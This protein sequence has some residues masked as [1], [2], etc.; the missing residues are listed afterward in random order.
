MM[1]KLFGPLLVSLSFV[2]MALPTLAHQASDKGHQDMHK[3]QKEW[4]I[5]GDAKAVTRTIEI[6][7]LDTMRFVPEQITVKQGE[8]IR[9]TVKNVGKVM[10]ELVIGTKQELDMHAEMMKKHPNMEHDEPYMA[11]VSPGKKAEI[12]WNFNRAGQFDFACLLPGH[13]EAGMVGKINVVA[14]VK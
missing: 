5:G 11:H 10:H 6:T 3:E 4:G 9:L 12:I 1:K 13:Y 8:T 7:M 14:G 2:T